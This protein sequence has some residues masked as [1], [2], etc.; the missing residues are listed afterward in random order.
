MTWIL[1]FGGAFSCAGAAF[2]W[3]FFMNS[4]RAR[5]FVNMMGR[6]GARILYGVLGLFLVT[7]GALQLAGVLPSHR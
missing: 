2:D 7:M 6:K 4:R 1:L 5:F 3:D